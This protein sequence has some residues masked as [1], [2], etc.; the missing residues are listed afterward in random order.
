MVEVE[1]F[2]H[3]FLAIGQD[4]VWATNILSMGVEGR[5]R[6]AR[7][8]RDGLA[9]GDSHIGSTLEGEQVLEEG[10]EHVVQST[11]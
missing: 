10:E 9:R 5:D 7:R 2:H 1:C 4:V 3:M 11:V 8:R 6:S